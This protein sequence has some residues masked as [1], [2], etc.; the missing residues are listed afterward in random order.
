ML[1][2]GSTTGTGMDN[3]LIVAIALKTLAADVI[4]AHNHPSGAINPSTEDLIISKRLSESLKMIDI[5]IL[6]HFIITP[7]DGYYSFADKGQI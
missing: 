2:I 6:N 3:K 7:I 1:S 5:K 4:L